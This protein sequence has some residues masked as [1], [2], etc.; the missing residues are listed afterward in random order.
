MRCLPDRKHDPSMTM[1]THSGTSPQPAVMPIDRE[2]WRR[3]LDISNFVNSYYQYRDV[4]RWPD[5]RKILIIGPGQGLD[6]AVFRSRGYKVVTFDIDATFEPDVIGSVHDL[7]SFADR[8]FDVAIAS[9][10]L[11][12]LPPE[13]LDRSLSELARVARYCIVYLPVTGR[14]ARLRVTPGI[15]GWD[16]SFTISLF[17]F[18]DKPDPRRP[19][20]CRGQHYWEVGRRG[21]T[22]KNLHRRFSKFFHVAGSYHNPDWIMSMN[23]IL[24]A[25]APA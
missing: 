13:Y 15:R 24:E 16:W 18:F 4:Q 21:F 25:R 8:E 23:Y 17:N 20:Y 11:E 9:H 7:S 19:K 10:V 22:R 14:I 2:E 12:H 3:R 1:D 6:T 5:A